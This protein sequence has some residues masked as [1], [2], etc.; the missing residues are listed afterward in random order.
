MHLWMT[1]LQKTQGND[2]C[3][4]QDNGCLRE[5]GRGCDWG[6]ARGKKGLL[7]ELAEFCVSWPPWWLL[8]NNQVFVFIKFHS[9]I[10]LFGVVFYIYLFNFEIMRFLNTIKMIH[11][12]GRICTVVSNVFPGIVAVALQSWW[13]K[14]QGR[15]PDKSVLV[16]P[17]LLQIL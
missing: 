16:S 5:V 4:S 1:K 13:Q 3:A 2:Y 9:V 7:R 6:G 10:N 14:I 12:R 11:F 8:Y 15:P 17:L